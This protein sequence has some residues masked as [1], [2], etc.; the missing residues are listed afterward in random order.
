MTRTLEE[1]HAAYHAQPPAATL[2]FSAE[3]MKIWTQ[4]FVVGGPP[5]SVDPAA[6][7]LDQAKAI[8]CGARRQTYG[9]PE[10]NLGCIA[11]LWNAYLLRTHAKEA[12]SAKYSIMVSAADVA[13]MMVLMK[14]A[15]LAETPNHADSWRDIAGYAACGARASGANLD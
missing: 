7:L 3:E 1:L 4:S 14:C 6:Q 11:A 13:A 5:Q 8:V 9:N 10:D 12:G 2:E 15:R